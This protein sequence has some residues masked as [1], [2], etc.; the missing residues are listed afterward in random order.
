MN[1]PWLSVLMPVYNGGK[2]L[3]Q[4]L[5]SIVAQGDKDIECIAV[6]DGSTD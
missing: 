1:K 6:D 3:A 2:Y 4:A 5:D